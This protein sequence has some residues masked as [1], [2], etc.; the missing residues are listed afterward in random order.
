MARL[1]TK[2]Q[3]IALST[4]TTDMVLVQ[5]LLIEIGVHLQLQPPILWNDNLGAQALAYNLV[6]RSRTKH[7]D[8]DVR[9]IINLIINHK[10][11]V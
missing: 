9:F 7:I 2:A 10:I 11:E 1:G 6:S 3:Y 4:V 8:L 5:N